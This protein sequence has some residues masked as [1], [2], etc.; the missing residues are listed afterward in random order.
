MAHW[1][2]H[3][4]RL[5]IRNR[6]GWFFLGKRVKWSNTL[7][8]SLNLQSNE[9]MVW[10]ISEIIF[11]SDGGTAREKTDSEVSLS[12]CT[13][14][15]S[16]MIRSTSLITFFNRKRKIEVK[17]FDGLSQCWPGI[18]FMKYG[19]L[20]LCVHL[21]ALQANVL[22]TRPE[23]NTWRTHKN[24]PKCYYCERSAA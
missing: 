2:V 22:R 8:N 14:N 6:L 23:K 18:V 10:S 11:S 12:K 19:Q 17:Q 3:V 5:F 21:F 20:F 13:N 9:L 24:T 4:V 1:S 7:M 16:N 15:I